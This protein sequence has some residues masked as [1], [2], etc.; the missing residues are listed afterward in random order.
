M[1]WSPAGMWTAGM[2]P[3]QD[4]YHMLDRIHECKLQWTNGVGT[5]SCCTTMLGPPWINQQTNS[6]QGLLWH[7]VADPADCLNLSLFRNISSTCLAS[8]R[9]LL[10]YFVNWQFIK[11]FRYFAVY[12]FPS[13]QNHQH[14][15]FSEVNERKLLSLNLALQGHSSLAL[16]RRKCAGVIAKWWI[17]FIAHAAVRKGKRVAEWMHSS[18]NG[19]V[20]LFLFEPID[21][22]LRN[23]RR[24]KAHLD[25]EWSDRTC[26]HVPERHARK[27]RG[28][29]TLQSNVEPYCPSVT[30][31]TMQG[32]ILF[33][34]LC[35][36]WYIFL[37]THKKGD[38]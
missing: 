21:T 3:P 20:V 28:L 37:I 34:S 33:D 26:R 13:L 12:S 32:C 19:A 25:F 17:I 23:R 1:G 7:F 22:D 2:Q 15:H 5:Q 6:S 27:T 8:N 24:G 36:L 31:Q 35:P 9:Y 18:K 29:K 4:L 11:C 30:F 14:K 10:F 16:A 38:P